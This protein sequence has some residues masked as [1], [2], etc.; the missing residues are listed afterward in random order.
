MTNDEEATRRV[1]PERYEASAAPDPELTQV[2]APHVA[3]PSGSPD[4]QAAPAGDEEERTRHIDSFTPPSSPP[5][6]SGPA[7]GPS[8][9]PSFGPPPSQQRYAPPPPNQPSTPTTPN[10]PPGAGFGGYPPP[11]GPG[12]YPPPTGP[13]AY[14]SAGGPHQ[15]FPQN[16]QQASYPPHSSMPPQG[17]PPSP[18]EM[19]NAALA[20]GN[21]LIEQLMARGV[22]GELIKQA[23][24]QGWRGQSGLVYGSFG[25]ALVLCLIMTAV[26]GVVGVV[27]TDIIW[28]ALIY[29]YFAIG[30]KLAHQFIAYGVCLVGAVLALLSALYSAATLVYLMSLGFVSTAVLSIITVVL[31]AVSGV[32]LAYIGW[33]VRAAIKRF[34][35]NGQL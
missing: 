29:L 11:T 19:A 23:W 31:S 35:S 24:F 7:A 10:Y 30:N 17:P 13:G 12:A 26:P 34:Q 15:P 33:R 6:P 9:Q 25:V 16:P 22:R 5:P 2:V 14:P 4:P 32:A 28:A 8:S 1:S 27:L 20:K 21:S 3:S 18:A